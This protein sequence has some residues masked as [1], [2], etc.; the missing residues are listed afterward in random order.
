MIFKRTGIVIVFALFI[1]SGCAQR[2]PVTYRDVETTNYVQIVLTSGKMIEGT[3]L[4][5]EPH[6]LTIF[7]KNRTKQSV[8]QSSIKEI[9][10]KPPVY[11]DFGKGISEEE[12]RSVQKNRNATVYGIGGGAL[13]LGASFF[14][15]SLIG[16]NMEEGGTIVAA[17]TVVG[18]G[19]GTILFVNGGKAKDREEA[20]DKIVEK[21]RVTEYQKKQVKQK[22]AGSEEIDKLIEKEKEEQEKLREEREDLLKK[23]QETETNQ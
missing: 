16:H 20:I 6:Q 12:I 8:L 1:F 15:S 18:G 10:R 21:R 23:L 4:N 17:S 11:D 3:V 14:V 9:K 7:K 19:I 13:S 5:V 22:K 2:N